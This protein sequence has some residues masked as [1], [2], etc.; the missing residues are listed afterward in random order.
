[1]KELI[2]TK[3]SGETAIFEMDKLRQSMRNSGADE[4]QIEK[5][6]K[7]IEPRLYQGITTKKIYKW[8]F[9]MLKKQSK[10]VA[11]RYQL[12]RA[13]MELGPSGFP[14]ETFI[15]HVLK[16]QGY[17]TKVGIIVQGTCVTHEIDVIASTDKEHL[18]VECKFHSEPGKM[19]D[20]KVPLYIQS[21]YLDVKAQWELQPALKGKDIQGWV[22]TNTRF[23]PDAVQYGRCIGLNLLSWD[24]PLNNSL[25]EMID[26]F[27]LYPL[28]CL[29]GLTAAEKTKLLSQKVLFCTELL[30]DQQLLHG[31]ALSEARISSVL[32]EI[33]HLN[34]VK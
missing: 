16:N 12:K 25:K 9:A 4:A 26:K 30:A 8:A 14:F 6:V 31:L 13:I 1:M 7:D 3:A 15:S 28:T 22:V 11:A 29:T 17:H 27:G 32:T 19:S 2:I 20:V 33:R 21:R 24:Y 18:M 10:P 23:S 5:V 34:A